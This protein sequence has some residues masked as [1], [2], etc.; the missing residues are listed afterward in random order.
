MTDKIAESKVS[1]VAWNRQTWQNYEWPEGG[2]EWSAPWGGTH[3]MW[4]AFIMPRIARFVPAEHILE[5]APGFGRCTQYL[6]SLCKRLTAVD[7]APRCVQA[8]RERFRVGQADGAAHLELHV[9]DGMSL[10]MVNDGSVDFAFSWASLVHARHE[11][12]RSYVL[13]LSRVLRPG[14]AA[15]LHHSNYGVYTE[16]RDLDQ[17]RDAPGNRGADMT[18]EKLRADCADCELLCAAQELIPQ[19]GPGVY[20]D[21]CSLVFRPRT[22]APFEPADTVVLERSDLR[23]EL[24]L[25]R[26]LSRLYEACGVDRSLDT[27]EK[28]S[29]R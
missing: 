17:I 1:T 11:A 22:D 18:A 10:P 29:G 24:H 27:D 8:C 2:D 19:C 3:A 26:R 9:N 12:M 15:F 23:A 20:N 28:G 4:H 5:I 16:G 7:L 14:G 25:I 21:C 13:E 6:L